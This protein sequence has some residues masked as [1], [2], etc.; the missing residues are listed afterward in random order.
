MQSRARVVGRRKRTSRDLNISF[1]EN[2]G[3]KKHNRNTDSSIAQISRYTAGFLKREF[4]Y[5]IVML[6]FTCACG[7]ASMLFGFGGY[8]ESI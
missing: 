8:L 4:C 5:E 1:T 3:V 2:R 6:L 7:K